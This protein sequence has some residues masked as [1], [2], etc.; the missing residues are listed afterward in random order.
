MLRR[1][2]GRVHQVMTAFTSIGGA[3]ARRREG[4]VA[5]DVAMIELDDADARRLRRERRVARQGRR[6]R[7]PGHRRGARPRGARLGDQRDRAAARRGAR[8]AA[9][10]GRAGAAVRGGAALP[11]DCRGDRRDRRALA[12]G[13]RAGR[14][15]MRAGGPRAGRGHDRRGVE[16]ASGRRRCA[17]RPRRVRPTSARTTRRSSPPS[18]RRAATCAG[19]SSAGC[20]ATRPSSSRARSRSSTRSTASSSPR[21]SAKRAAGVLQPVLLSVNVAGEATKGGVTPEA[22]PALARAIARRRRASASTA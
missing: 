19:T 4:V 18:A 22:A 14:R 17:R 8:R 2:S 11:A 5:T 20:S 15:G 12:R 16:D 9:R 13:P 21:S 6:V 1:L 7:D 3:T 10:A